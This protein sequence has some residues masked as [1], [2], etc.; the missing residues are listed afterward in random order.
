ML[1]TPQ[2]LV[3]W[4]N[5]VKQ[6]I[7]DYYEHS[8]NMGLSHFEG[9][10]PIV[11]LVLG[12]CCL[13]VFLS[14]ILEA[15]RRVSS[16]DTDAPPTFLNKVNPI[17]L[18]LFGVAPLLIFYGAYLM[19]GEA[20]ADVKQLEYLKSQAIAGVFDDYLSTYKG[21]AKTLDITTT[22]SDVE[23]GQLYM[24]DTLH[25]GVKYKN[26][27]VYVT[28]DD[29]FPSN[30]FIPFNSEEYL[31][32]PSKDHKNYEDRYEVFYLSYY[33]TKGQ[34][35]SFGYL[36]EVDYIYNLKIVDNKAN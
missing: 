36:D 35:K 22:K 28:Y 26:Q 21:E 33:N 2:V 31:E 23:S 5:L 16:L 15:L 32:V 18:A 20:K 30:T 3:G 9:L 10:S 8:D 11:M 19:V 7:V 27:L 14:V 29:R 6:R 17:I 34:H 24:I 1:K 25:E 12:V 4:S 13:M